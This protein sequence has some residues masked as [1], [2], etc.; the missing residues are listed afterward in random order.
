MSFVMALQGLF[1]PLCGNY[2]EVQLVNWII[3]YLTVPYTGNEL[4][5]K[6]LKTQTKQGG[7]IYISNTEKG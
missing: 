6:L 2:T 3:N 7:K 1:A 4:N 5:M